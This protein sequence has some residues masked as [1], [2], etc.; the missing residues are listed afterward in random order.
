MRPVLSI[1][2]SA[3][4]LAGCANVYDKTAETPVCRRSA[5]T[6][7][8]AAVPVSA[9]GIAMS[10]GFVIPSR[11]VSASG[12]LDMEWGNPH[13]CIREKNEIKPPKRYD[14][15]KIGRAV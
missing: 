2:A 13:D 7:R 15:R 8:S 12:K 3:L 10:N 9:P 6:D 14:L 1:A 11:G 4:V 5:E